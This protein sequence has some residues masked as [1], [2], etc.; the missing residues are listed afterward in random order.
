MGATNGEKAGRGHQA[1]FASGFG[2]GASRILRLARRKGRRV[3]EGFGENRPFRRRK[4]LKGEKPSRGSVSG[5]DRFSPKPRSKSGM[6]IQPK[7]VA[8]ACCS[9]RSLW[10]RALPCVKRG[11]A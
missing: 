4:T 1:V 10:T 3:P 6:S 7:A 5:T 11:A 8:A 2:R 9:V